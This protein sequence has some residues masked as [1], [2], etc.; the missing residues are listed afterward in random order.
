M[1]V[2]EIIKELQKLPQDAI[3]ITASDEEGNS[4]DEVYNTPTLGLFI[5]HD[6]FAPEEHIK[7]W[8]ED[9]DSYR[10]NGI[11]AVCLN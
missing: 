11:K 2:S 7:E 9:Y 3:V 4:F 10:E 1:T 8:P 6:G 5:K